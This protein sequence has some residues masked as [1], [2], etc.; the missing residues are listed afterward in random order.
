MNNRLMCSAV[1]RALG[2]AG[3]LLAL[4]GPARAEVTVVST[5]PANRDRAVDPKVNTLRI[6]FSEPIGTGG[7][8]LV[9][10][11]NGVSPAFVTPANVRYEDGNRV[12]IISVRLKPS[13]TY[14]IG[15]NNEQY[16]NFRAAAPPNEPV[17][18]YVLTFRTGPAPKKAA[19]K[20]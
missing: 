7:M 17:T 9:Q 20:R 19:P 11:P 10:V 5:F 8:S 12:F 18:P 14:G 16:G 13:T 3:L 2:F 15:V 1:A 6:R 4:A